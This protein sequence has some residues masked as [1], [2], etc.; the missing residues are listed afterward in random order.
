MRSK[1][2]VCAGMAI[3]AIVGVADPAEADWGYCSVY[4]ADGEF[5]VYSDVWEANWSERYAMNA[6][7]AFLSHLRR[8]GYPVVD[9]DVACWFDDSRRAIRRD[10]RDSQSDDWDRGWEVESVAWTM[11]ASTQGVRGRSN[12]EQGCYFGECPDDPTGPTR[13]A[14]DP[15][16][17]FPPSNQPR[18][19]PYAQVCQVYQPVLYYCHL[20]PRTALVGQSCWCPTQWG[21]LVGFAVAPQQ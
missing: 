2:A 7:G 11:R 19:Q 17:F 1:L 9:D 6:E 12:G 13:G 10:L 14:D 8:S 5:A 20:P 21:P 15:P 18:Y 3:A 16:P 4:T